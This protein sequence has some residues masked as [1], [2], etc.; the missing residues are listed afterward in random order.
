MNLSLGEPVDARLAL[1]EALQQNPEL[2]VTRV[3]LVVAYVEL[4]DTDKAHEAAEAVKQD[5]PNVTVDRLAAR[6]PANA[7]KQE[8]LRRALAT[9]GL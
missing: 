1:L 4:G 7:A 2:K 5:Y 3:P 8:Q 6:I 9:A